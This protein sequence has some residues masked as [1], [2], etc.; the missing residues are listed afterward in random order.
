MVSFYKYAF[1]TETVFFF[2]KMIFF[3]KNWRGKFHVEPIVE[4]NS[5]VEKVSETHFQQNWEAE[6]ISVVD[7]C[8]V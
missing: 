7:G 5:S 4:S 8:L 6:K 2:K 3:Q 1:L